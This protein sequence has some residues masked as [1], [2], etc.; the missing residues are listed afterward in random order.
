METY[1]R[2]KEDGRFS[3]HPPAR[4]PAPP[5][6]MAVPV[7]PQ[8]YRY[9]SEQGSKAVAAETILAHLRKFKAFLE[10][11]ELGP[12][13]TFDDMNGKLVGRYRR[14][15]MAP[16][17]CSSEWRGQP[18]T[19]TSKRGVC[20]ATFRRSFASVKAAFNMA[21]EDRIV[22]HL[23]RLPPLPHE[24]KSAPRTRVLTMEEVGAMLAYAADDE[25]LLNWIRIMLATGVRPIAGMRLVPSTQW[26][27]HLA[28]LDLHP[29]GA[30]RTGKRNPIVP[31][32]PQLLENLRAH[33]GPWIPSNVKH[34]TLTRRWRL[35]R[36][37]LGFTDEVTPK[38]F[39][40]TVA[41]CLAEH[42]AS[43]I[44]IAM[45]LGHHVVPRWRDRELFSPRFY[46]GVVP[47]LSNM[48]DEAHGCANTWREKYA[49]AVTRRYSRIIIENS[50]A[51]EAGF[52]P[53]KVGVFDMVSGSRIREERRAA[54]PVY[55]TWLLS[56]ASVGVRLSLLLMPWP[57]RLGPARASLQLGPP[58][59]PSGLPG[60]A[61][62]LSP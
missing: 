7:I 39:R 14:W 40:Y 10:S 49:V 2:N 20:G 46:N 26:I 32:I 5:D 53:A 61:S 38:T 27:D 11:D 60:H 48:W 18:Y 55:W 50:V 51:S 36:E 24:L 15:M 12:N 30:P 33:N 62:G 4:L 43:D 13:A 1:C 6:P 54:M 44:H 19:L 31:I 34:H 3:M 42:G 22:P 8:L 21:R 23:W 16:H 56:R 35:M 37:A 25:A 17:S 58:E 47:I 9:W 52:D 28:R 45:L 29:V 59:C 41:T 57:Q